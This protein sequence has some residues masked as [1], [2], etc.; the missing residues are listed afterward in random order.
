MLI[1]LPGGWIGVGN[2]AGWLGVQLGLAWLLLRLPARWFD[3]PRARAGGR[4]RWFYERVLR[5][6]DWKDR[7]PDGARWISHG[8]S[9]RNLRGTDS[10]YLRR[11]VAETRRG[12][13]CHWLAIACLP[14]FSVWNPW[15]GVWVNAAY[16]LLANLPCIM[17]QRY[18]RGRL[19]GLLA[20]A[21]GN[22]G[23][24]RPGSS[25]AR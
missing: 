16:A 13:L 12:E 5:V 15:W 1:K 22:C 10:E 21:R 17:A 3:W 8:F 14:V 2:V 4:R 18:N 19:L 20:R 7:L 23:P 11:F 25:M 24:S 6:K 9:K